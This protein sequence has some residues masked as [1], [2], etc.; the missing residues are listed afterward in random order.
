MQRRRVSKGGTQTRSGNINTATLE[1][2]GTTTL[3]K[4]EGAAGWGYG[5]VK[6][7]LE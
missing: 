5:A 1:E 2:C 6:G 7:L 3:A 4:A